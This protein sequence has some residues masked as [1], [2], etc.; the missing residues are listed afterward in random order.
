MTPSEREREAKLQAAVKV[1]A[2]MSPEAQ[3]I[4]FNDMKARLDHDKSRNQIWSYY[5]ETG[6][7]RRELYTKH[8]EFFAAGL[9]HQE[10]AFI[11]A[12]R[13]VAPWTVMETS[14]GE[15]RISELN[16]GSSYGVQ[17]WDG[18]A[19]SIAA[20]EPSFLK[21]IEPAFRLHLD[22]GGSFDC[23]RKHRLL[24]TEG[25]LSLDQIVRVSGG[26]RFRKTDSGSRSSCGADGRLRGERPLWAGGSVR[27]G[28]PLTGDALR[29]TLHYALADAMVRR[30]GRSHAYLDAALLSIPHD[31]NPPADPYANFEALASWCDAGWCRETRRELRRFVDASDRL[32]ASNRSV[33]SEALSSASHAGIPLEFLRAAACTVVDPAPTALVDGLSTARLLPGQASL[34]SLDGEP[35]TEIFLASDGP[36]LSGG[37]RIDSIVPLGYMPIMDVTVPGVNNYY[38]QGIYHHNSGKTH[39][40]CYE[41]TLHLLGRYPKWWIG[42]R[43]DRPVTVW[44]AGE[45]AKAVRESMQEKLLGRPG[46]YGTGMVPGDLLSDVRP[47]AGVADTIDL[48]NV[49]HATGKKSRAVFK[50]YEQGRESFQSSAVDIIVLDEEPPADVYTESLTRTLSTKPGQPSGMILASFTPLKGLS[51]LVLQF[52]PGGRLPATPEERKSAW[53][54]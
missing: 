12:N 53:G 3:R 34:Q 26:W 28:L 29:R 47:R 51:G 15:R 41:A 52:L 13:C 45:D 24:T 25:W 31:L 23:S 7:L 30:Q 36:L 18:A 11:A 42:R 38:A 37:V 21:C 49:L 1:F 16:D 40:V 54:W 6:P 50:A 4:V 44:F 43:F 32:E 5:P 9:F 46:N 10:R 48:F 33:P 35:G 20:A 14:R 2:T 19:R 39:A 8:M 17:A 27:S 22:T